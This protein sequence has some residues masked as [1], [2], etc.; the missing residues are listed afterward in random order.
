MSAANDRTPQVRISELVEAADRLADELLQLRL[1]PTV[2]GAEGVS[3]H[4]HA[5]SRVAGALAIALTELA[6]R[7]GIE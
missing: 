4:L 2:V 6:E 5:M 7:E 1:D 3:W